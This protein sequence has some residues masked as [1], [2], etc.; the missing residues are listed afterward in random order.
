MGHEEMVVLASMRTLRQCG[1]FALA[2]NGSDAARLS[3][4]PA[5]SS[6]TSPSVW[7]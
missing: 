4:V 1:S 7:F 6:L 3:V 2:V 5:A